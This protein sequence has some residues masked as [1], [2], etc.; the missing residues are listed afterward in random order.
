MTLCSAPCMHLCV[1]VGEL[2]HQASLEAVV[3]AVLHLG[4]TEV[5]L[6]RD[7][8]QQ[9]KWLGASLTRTV[10]D[11]PWAAWSGPVAKGAAHKSGMA[12]A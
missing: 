4:W 5:D 3:G 8:Q 1:P 11:L 10:L 7:G 6:L 12:G 2:D 9:Y